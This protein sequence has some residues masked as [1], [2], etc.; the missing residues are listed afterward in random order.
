[1]GFEAFLDVARGILDKQSKSLLDNEINC[2][3]D[4]NI[5]VQAMYPA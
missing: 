5:T 2:E 1:M 4:Q 3:S